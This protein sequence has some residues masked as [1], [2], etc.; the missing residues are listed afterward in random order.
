MENGTIA[1]ILIP[2]LLSPVVLMI[3]MHNAGKKKSSKDP[4]K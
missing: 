2:L 4:E 3:W 1:L